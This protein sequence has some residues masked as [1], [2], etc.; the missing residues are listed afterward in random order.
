MNIRE[1]TFRGEDKAVLYA[2]GVCGS[3]S[4]PKTY[5]A[6][7]ERAHEAARQAAEACCAPRKCDCGAE[8]EKYW[9][10]CERCRER[11]K[12]IRA[13]V[14]DTS[15]YDGPVSTDGGG[16][17]GEGYSSSLDGLI[18]HCRGYGEPLPAYCHPCT[19]HPLRL[20]AD[21]ILE[22]AMD[23]MHED[24]DD[25]VEGY[26]D[27]CEFVAKWNDRQH[28]VSYFEDRSRVIVIDQERFDALIAPVTAEGRK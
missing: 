17:W 28:C 27:L 11:N 13:Q 9:T 4:S 16:D 3:L 12:L 20:D 1:L 6:S 15:A 26:D 10:A 24:A 25:Q 18:E 19:P 7:D 23:G 5:A 2:C 14:I 22:S 21:S 8:I